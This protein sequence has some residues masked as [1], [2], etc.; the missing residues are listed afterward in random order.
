MTA[1]THTVVGK[2]VFNEGADGTEYLTRLRA[3]FGL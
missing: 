2:V 1:T 3:I